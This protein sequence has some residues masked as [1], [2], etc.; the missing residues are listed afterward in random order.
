M[1]RTNAKLQS[2]DKC[3]STCSRQNVIQDN[4]I[5]VIKLRSPTRVIL[6]WLHQRTFVYHRKLHLVDIS[7]IFKCPSRTDDWQVT[8]VSWNGKDAPQGML[9][10]YK[11]VER[12]RVK[13]GGAIC[14]SVWWIILRLSRG[15]EATVSPRCIACRTQPP[16]GIAATT[17]KLKCPR[18]VLSQIISIATVVRVTHGFV[19]ISS[20]NMPHLWH[21]GDV[22]YW[23]RCVNS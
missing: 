7:T 10:K 17:T 1:L 6:K 21:I 2:R 5:I 12:A 13:G 14:K 18:V 9:C 3:E 8:F 19:V 4:V 11:R 23:W 20:R 15:S 16:S 22:F